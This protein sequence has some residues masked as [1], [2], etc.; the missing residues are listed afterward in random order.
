MS[1]L[2]A[3]LLAAGIGVAVYTFSGSAAATTT[4]GREW[5]GRFGN[6]AIRVSRSG[7]NWTWYVEGVGLGNEA[8]A[9]A[10]LRAAARSA[11]ESGK[12]GD[13]DTFSVQSTDGAVSATANNL[14]AADVW[15]WSI[16]GVR[17]GTT[18]AQNVATLP[19]R[20]AAIVE[21]LDA[22]RPET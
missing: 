20:G 10:A 18:L 9:I 16:S 1:L 13:G 21:L 19:T 4:T 11:Q 5:T 3:A 22:L 2:R 6:L 12:V 8:T 14:G 17:S 7:V 15:E